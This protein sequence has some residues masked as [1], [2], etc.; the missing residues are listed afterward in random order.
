M[1]LLICQQI[2][3]APVHS[4][5]VWQ[6]PPRA[7]PDVTTANFCAPNQDICYRLGCPDNFH[8]GVKPFGAE[9][10]APLT[11][12]GVVENTIEKQTFGMAKEP[13]LN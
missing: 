2:W 11:K 3:C 10:M 9:K 1:G 7:V 8:F 4:R 13:V 6:V 5:P 12:I